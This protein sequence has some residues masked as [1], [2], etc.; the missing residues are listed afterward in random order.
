[1]N[2]DGSIKSVNAEMYKTTTCLKI[3]SGSYL[4]DS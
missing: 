4:S 3:K 2:F 1:M